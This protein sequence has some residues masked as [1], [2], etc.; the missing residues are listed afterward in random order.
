MKKPLEKPLIPMVDMWKTIDIPSFQKMYHR[1]GLV[2]THHLHHDHDH[3]HDH[4]KRFESGGWGNILL[5][6]GSR[7]CNQDASSPPC[8]WLVT[9]C[10]CH[11]YHHHHCLIPWH[12]HHDHV[13][14]TK[15]P[16]L[17]WMKGQTGLADLAVLVNL[18]EDNLQRGKTKHYIWNST[19]ANM[20]GRK[21]E[22]YG[23]WIYA[24]LSNWIVMEC[25]GNAGEMNREL[26]LSSS[27]TAHIY[28]YYL[29]LDV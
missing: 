5:P 16:N 4:D 28:I 3:D 12:N 1:R 26:L 22:I 15:L 2:Q 9:H 25:T 7:P 18:S 14:L 21:Y 6:S 10:P 20:L 17:A 27:S 29:T 11:S 13:F 8:W 24:N 19:N 23:I